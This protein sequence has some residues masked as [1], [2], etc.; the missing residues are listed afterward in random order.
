MK[1]ALANGLLAFLVA[2]IAIAA[3]LAQA[4]SLVVDMLDVGQGDGILIR[5]EEKAVL[6]DAGLK[7]A[8][9]V[10]QLKALG[11]D[12]LDL[13]VATHPH[14]DHMGG[15]QQVLE[16]FPPKL[17][18]D[19]GMPHTTQTYGELMAY[20]EKAGIAYRTAEKGMTLKMGTEAVFQVLFPEGKPL[21][22]TRS[23]LNSNSVVLRLDHQEV[24]FLFTGDA[25]EP[26]EAAL[27]ADNLQ[28][29]D[30]LKVAHHGS[31]HATTNR[32]LRAVKPRFA[33]ISTG[34]EN[35][36]GHP[37][38]ECLDRLKRANVLVFRTDQSGQVRVI[39]VGKDVEMLEGSAAELAQMRLPWAPSAQAR[40]V[41]GSR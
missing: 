22:G 26:T 23:D 37:T 5:T 2:F 6:I 39:S 29:V 27:L 33:L 40:T 15:M 31:A 1:R 20:I 34:T 21:R 24:S 9:T 4:G 10:D 38:D 19:N 14:A 28:P 35:R 30:V 32:F 12:H 25:E 18:V 8:R 7:K 16:A 17:Y 36:Y 13:V 11:V 3:G 41:T